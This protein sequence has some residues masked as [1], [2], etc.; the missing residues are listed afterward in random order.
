LLPLA[1]VVVFIV[2]ALWIRRRLAAEG[3]A[4][5]RRA[6]QVVMLYGLLWLIVYDVTFAV[7]YVGVVPGLLLL[8]LLPLAYL[9][10]KLMRAW[11][12]V[13][14]LSQTPEFQRAR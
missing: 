14:S 10:V 3:R 12:R 5:E 9:S 13:L 11:S 6:G 2:L 1:A 4:G 7:G 8:C